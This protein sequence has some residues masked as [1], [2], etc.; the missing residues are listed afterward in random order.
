MGCAATARLA[1]CSTGA[2]EDGRTDA[3][4]Q[5]I[6]RLGQREPA[7]GKDKARG[8]N[9]AACGQICGARTVGIDTVSGI[10]LPCR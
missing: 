7:P 4:R 9:G 5:L 2:I 1:E 8:A 10:A 3:T 6:L